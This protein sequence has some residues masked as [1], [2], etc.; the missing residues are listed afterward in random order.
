MGIM[1]KLKSAANFVTGGGAEINISMPEEVEM[2]TPF[3]I[4]IKC[5]AKNDINPKR[6]YVKLQSVEN[7][8]VEDRDYDEDGDTDYEYIHRQSVIFD[9]EYDI[10][11]E[12]SLSEGEEKTWDK[13]VVVP[14]EAQCTYEG[15]HAKHQ[16]RLQVGLDVPGNDPDSGWVYFDAY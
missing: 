12:L 1:D 2:G 8:E 10:E 3:Q 14:D 16:W 4:N 9:E 7:V 6:V 15:V 5:L 13:E 11:G